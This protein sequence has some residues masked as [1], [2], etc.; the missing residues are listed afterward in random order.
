ML[1]LQN[2]SIEVYMHMGWYLGQGFWWLLGSPLFSK[3]EKGKSREDTW[4]WIVPS[5]TLISKFPPFRTVRHKHL[6][7]TLLRQYLA[8]CPKQIMS[9]ISLYFDFSRHFY[10]LGD[11]FY[12]V[13]V[14]SPIKTF[15]LDLVW[16]K[17]FVILFCSASMS[18]ISTVDFK[19]LFLCM[20]AFK[21]C[22]SRIFLSS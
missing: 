4:E 3:Y 15:Y 9:L 16:K 11:V 14:D 12:K 7:F 8:A 2:K 5:N 20:L 19:I 1:F 22:L 21:I 17:D 10:S 6:L 18:S 13:L